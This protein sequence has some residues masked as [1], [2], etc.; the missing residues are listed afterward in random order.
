VLLLILAGLWVLVAEDEVDLVGGTALV[1]AKH[2]NVGGCVGEF[3]LVELLVLL[4]ELEIGTT[5]LKAIWA[6]SVCI[7]LNSMRHR[8]CMHTL[9]LNLVLYDQGLA[10]V[11]NLLWEFGGDGVVSSLILYDQTLVSN[12]AAEN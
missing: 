12:H 8:G 11:V 3:V 9:K 1:G 4:E 6:M 2:D 7:I 5:T 10:L